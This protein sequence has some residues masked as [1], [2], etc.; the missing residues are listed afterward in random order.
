M[1]PAK[2]STKQQIT[3]APVKKRYPEVK[4]YL[5]KA[6]QMHQVVLKQF[7]PLSDE[8]TLCQNELFTFKKDLEL[9][10][11]GS[12]EDRKEVIEKYG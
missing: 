5:L 8:W 6:I 7:E 1:Q 2:P 10:E 9:L 3:K 12:Y 4:E 11:R